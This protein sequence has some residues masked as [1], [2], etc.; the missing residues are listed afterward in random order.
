MFWEE[1][2][3][4]P[5]VSW[6]Q[7]QAPTC[8]TQLKQVHVQRVVL[9]SSSGDSCLGRWLIRKDNCIVHVALRAFISVWEWITQPVVRAKESKP[10][11][12]TYPTI[13]NPYPGRQIHSRSE[14]AAC[15]L[16]YLFPVY[17]NTDTKSLLLHE[18]LVTWWTP[19]LSQLLLRT[20]P[21]LPLGFQSP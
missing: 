1:P 7:N 6:T 8:K 2:V 4:E 16:S 5:Q 21:W 19:R 11:H 9:S 17:L 14:F 15:H 20:E 3:W 12:Q 18:A 10:R 13:D